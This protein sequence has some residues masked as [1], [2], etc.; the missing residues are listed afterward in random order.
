[1]E[2]LSTL[3]FGT[4]TPNSQ[5]TALAVKTSHYSF[6]LRSHFWKR[7]SLNKRSMRSLA[8]HRKSDQETHH[9]ESGNAV[10]H[11]HGP[12]DVEVHCRSR[13]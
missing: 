3:T 5:H 10:H 11:D 1:V 8:C 12:E 6:F 4:D 13:E 2:P 7:R 9:D